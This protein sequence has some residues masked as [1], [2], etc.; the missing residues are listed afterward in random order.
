ET[1]RA[2]VSRALGAIERPYAQRSAQV[3]TR[4]LDEV[5]AA[6]VA[7]HREACLATH[8]RGEQSPEALDRRM[9]CL[10]RALRSTGALVD[11]LADAD[12]EA[13]DRAVDAV[14]A[15]PRPH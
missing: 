15:L 11:V 10:G 6:W 1:R 13:L 4:A 7:E 5:A 9:A 8:M 3:V 12:A 14:G 2:E